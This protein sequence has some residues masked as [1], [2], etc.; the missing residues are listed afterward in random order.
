MEGSL[1]L[2]KR[3]FGKQEINTRSASSLRITFLVPL[4]LS[5]FPRSR[6]SLNNARPSPR[7]NPEG[8]MK[9]DR[10][11]G[12]LSLGS[13]AP[14]LWSDIARDIAQV[15]QPLAGVTHQWD[16]RGKPSFGTWSGLP[17]SCSPL[18]GKPAT[19]T[20][21]SRLKELAPY[22]SLVKATACADQRELDRGN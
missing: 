12:Q 13:S 22:L 18:G 5:K 16:P 2:G 17:C 8:R 10:G 9:K 4:S 19:M 7:K 21:G 1:G 11:T 15:T 20:A 6:A 14:L 3:E